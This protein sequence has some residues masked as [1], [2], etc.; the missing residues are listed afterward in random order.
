[1][2]D[3]DA[4]VEVNRAIAAHDHPDWVD[5]AEETREELG[6]SYLDL[7]LDSLAAVTDR[8]QI[9]AWGLVICPPTQETLVRSILLGGVAPA[10]RGRG[11]GRALLAWQHARG[12]QQ[13]AGSSRTLPGWIVVS[14]D[15]RAPASGSTIRRAGFVPQRWFQS[16]SRTVDEP[17]P[18]GA[19]AP[20]VGGGI[21]IVPYA[22]EHSPQAHAARDA[23]FRGHG[24]SQP[25][26]DEQWE[27]M[28]TMSS[29][30]PAFS[31]VALDPS[32]RVVG[33]LLTL[34]TEESW[35]EQGFSS[36]YVWVIGVEPDARHQGAAR[37]MLAA[38][39]Q[40]LSAA[41]IERSVL[42]VATDAP[43]EGIE[44]F[45]GLGYAPQSI[46]V[47]YVQVH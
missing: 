34:V 1:M 38:H 45:T 40:A 43:G 2:D 29:A 19:V 3:V 33:L 16:L 47:Q 25:M 26:S 13:L 15:D 28:T 11:I 8:G 44:L 21:R 24:S 32:N 5:T 18:A 4:L 41:G 30:A 14:A 31:F 27:S 17:M 35:V 46:S 12:L 22:T 39:L 37:A 23:A 6:H 36:A 20:E 10:H 9:V 7:D 42:D